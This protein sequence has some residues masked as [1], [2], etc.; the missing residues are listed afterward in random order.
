MSPSNVPCKCPWNVLA[1]TLSYGSL[2]LP[3]SFTPKGARSR[4]LT[5]PV[6]LSVLSTGLSV[7]SIIS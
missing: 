4:V 6:P 1:Y 3:M 2:P 7:I 5:V